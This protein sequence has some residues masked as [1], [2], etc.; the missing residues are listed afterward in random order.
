MTQT[1]MP[2]GCWIILGSL[3]LAIP[4]LVR[5]VFQRMKCKQPVS[6]FWQH[7]LLLSGFL[8][9]STCLG[10]LFAA[11]DFVGLSSVGAPILV[12]L[13]GLGNQINLSIIPLALSIL[14]LF[15]VLI[16]KDKNLK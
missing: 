2:I 8:F 3:L 6:L 16:A 13:A 14:L 5:I 10:L 1:T 11:R 7:L 4:V 9:C 15:F 12:T